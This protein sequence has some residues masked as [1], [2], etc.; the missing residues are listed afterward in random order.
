VDPATVLLDEEPAVEALAIESTAPVRTG[1]VSDVFDRKLDP[2]AG[3]SSL[4]H[5]RFRDQ[6]MAA[7]VDDG[8][9][10]LGRRVRDLSIWEALAAEC[11]AREQLGM[12]D[13]AVT[14]AIAAVQSDRAAAELAGVPPKDWEQEVLRHFIR[15]KL[16]ECQKRVRPF[17]N[18][19]GLMTANY[20][21]PYHFIVLAADREAYSE[22]NSRFGIDGVLEATASLMQAGTPKWLPGR[23]R[24]VLYA[25][26]GVAPLFYLNER[27]LKRLRDAAAQKRKEKFLYTDLRFEEVADRVIRP[28][29]AYEDTYRFALALGL[30]L[31]VITRVETDGH[32]NG[33]SLLRLPNGDEYPDIVTLDRALQADSALGRA[34]LAQVNAEIERVTVNERDSVLHQT[35]NR[36][37]RHHQEAQGADR[38]AES[39]WWKQAE[40]TI[41]A[42]MNYGQYLVSV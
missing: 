21:H 20:S 19:N 25:R 6:L 2:R 29:E 7:I 36:A 15:N 26:E 10:R 41:L 24:I 18:L 23:D 34:V 3:G 39:R 33:R 35:L 16:F 12:E 4:L 8:V 17:W 30:E 1:I 22:A 5:E 27:E 32:L 13:A 28:H 14:A 11:N 37:K 38:P 40:Q 9:R 42:R 31:G